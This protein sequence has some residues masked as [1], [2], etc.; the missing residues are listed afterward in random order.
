MFPIAWAVVRSETKATWK[1]FLENLRDDLQIGR[2]GWAFVSDQQKGLMPAL[3][4]TLPEVEHRRCVSHIYAIWRRTHPGLELQRQ[5]WKCWKA[6]SKREF[7]QNPEGLKSLSPT[8]HEDI[9]K[10]DHKF[11]CRA[12]FD[13]GIKC[14]T[15]DNNLCEAFNGAIVP[16]RSQLGYSQLE[17]IGKL[18]MQKL[19]KNRDLADKWI[20]QLGPRIRRRINNTIMAN[21]YWRVQ[22]NGADG[23]ELSCG[24]D[25]YLVVCVSSGMCLGFLANTQYVPLETKGIL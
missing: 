14:E 21:N 17:Y 24:S 18:V 16:A 7:E 8:A 4:E 13:R 5:F 22:F 20:S 10:V 25:T 19:T 15:V 23:Y 11:W 9:V 2:A 1:W 6:T 12:F 3:Y